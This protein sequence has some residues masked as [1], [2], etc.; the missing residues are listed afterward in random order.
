MALLRKMLDGA[1]SA[2]APADALL[3]AVRRLRQAEEAQAPRQKAFNRLKRVLA[4]PAESLDS[5]A[6]RAAKVDAVEAFVST[7][8]IAIADAALLQ[9]ANSQLVRDA[10]TVSLLA[11]AAPT[12]PTSELVLE[13]K[14]LLEKAAAAGVP[15]DVIKLATVCADEAESAELTQNGTY[16]N[17]SL[18]AR[19]KAASERTA[20]VAPAKKDATE[21]AARAAADIAN[22]KAEEAAAE[23]SRLEVAVMAAWEKVKRADDEV[24]RHQEAASPA[25][26][27]VLA[28]G[29][30][31][32][33]STRMEAIAICSSVVVSSILMNPGPRC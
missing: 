23:R 7:D 20:M 12:Q 17:A 16:A 11:L 21:A 33:K 8:E 15:E 25:A 6:V 32:S 31:L 4:I 28:E 10:A 30:A 1:A 26:L 18:C 19:I 2:A 22:L 5:E 9:A 24:R 13:F 29:T 3:T 27:A 14:S